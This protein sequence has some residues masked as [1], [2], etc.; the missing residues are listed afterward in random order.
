MFGAF[1]IDI[2]MILVTFDRSHRYLQNDTKIVKIEVILILIMYQKLLCTV[3][4][5]FIGT[6]EKIFEPYPITIF[7]KDAIFLNFVSNF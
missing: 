4:F 7:K 6:K 5:F 1:N 2:I 3:E